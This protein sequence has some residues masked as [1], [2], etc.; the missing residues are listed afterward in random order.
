[1]HHDSSVFQIGDILLDGN[2]LHLTHVL[3]HRTDFRFQDLL[4]EHAPSIA[5]VTFKYLMQ[6]RR[7]LPITVLLSIKR[8]NSL[9]ARPQYNFVLDP[10]S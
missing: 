3:V 7:Y 4:N 9:Y 6:P 1:M 2:K 10:L 5:S 8:Y